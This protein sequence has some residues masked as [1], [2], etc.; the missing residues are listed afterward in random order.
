MDLARAGYTILSIE[1]KDEDRIMWM[2]IEKDGAK[3]VLKHVGSS[4]VEEKTY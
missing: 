1:T 4:Y 3:S 2:Q